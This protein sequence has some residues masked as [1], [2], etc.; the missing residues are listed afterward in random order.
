MAYIILITLPNKNKQWNLNLII[1]KDKSSE[2]LS[3]LDS[4]LT[5]GAEQ[6]KFAERVDKKAGKRALQYE[7]DCA[8]FGG[9]GR[10]RICTFPIAK[11]F[12]N[13]GFW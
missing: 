9:V 10:E 12:K 4:P 13:L 8:L 11:I 1:V 5:I 7:K 2:T 3:K 6:I